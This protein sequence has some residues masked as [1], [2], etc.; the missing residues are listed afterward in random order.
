M[1]DPLALVELAPDAI[2]C[3]DAG[4]VVQSWNRAAEQI[5]GHDA[6]TAVGLPLATLI[7]QAA[8]ALQNDARAQG[9]QDVQALRPDGE[10]LELTCRHRRL[11]D[12]GTIALFSDITRQRARQDGD[13]IR[14]RNGELFDS[15]P[16]AIVVVNPSGRIVFSNAQAQTLFGHDAAALVGEPVERLLPQRLRTQHRAHRSRYLDTPGLRPM[17]RGLELHGLHAQGHEFPVAIGL[18]PVR[19]EGRV[20]VIAAIR[21]IADRK[22]IES[23]LQQKNLEL[24]RANRAKDHFLATMSHELRTPLNAILGFTGLMLMRLPGP[25]TET[26][27]RQL[28]HVQSSGRHLLSLINDLLDLAKIGSGQLE[29]ACETIDA[30]EVIEEAVATLRP[31]ASVKRLDL[32]VDLPPGPCLVQ[33]DRR[34]LRQVVLNLGSNAIKFTARGSVVL[35]VPAAAESTGAS[36]PGDGWRLDVVDT[37]IGISDADQARLFQAFVQVG[38]WRERRM[39]GT[40]LGLH[41]SRQLAELMGGT[42]TVSSREGQGSCFSLWLRRG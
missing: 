42:L 13:V 30:R 9:H 28:G 5:F 15:L 21:D 37:G 22:A 7:G 4:G 16:D 19:L 12:G 24:E 11:D 3:C 27:E 1:T 39:E 6:A 35:R 29:L 33:A 8:V 41:L 25:L 26:Q 23:A 36:G 32:H 18:S 34:A 20:M 17:G 10:R 38:D 14:A 40:G 2:V 31:G